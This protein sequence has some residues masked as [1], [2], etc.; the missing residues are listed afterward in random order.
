LR[1]ERICPAERVSRGRDIPHART[2]TTV[3]DMARLLSFLAASITII[4]YTTVIITDQ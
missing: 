3:L 1:A 2:L 4:H